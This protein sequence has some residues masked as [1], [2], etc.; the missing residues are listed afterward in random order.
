MISKSFLYL[1]YFLVVF[2]H[3]NETYFPDANHG[4]HREIKGPRIA[5]ICVFLVI[6]IVFGIGFCVKRYR[7]R[8]LAQMQS[9]Q[10][11][12]SYEIPTTAFTT[13]KYIQDIVQ[14]VYLANNK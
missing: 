6:V 3:N 13:P 5:A 2:S 10:D 8:K 14:P 9:T 11:L 7:M 12:I 4:D 1:A